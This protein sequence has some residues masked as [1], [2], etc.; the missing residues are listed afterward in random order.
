VGTWGRIATRIALKGLTSMR[1]KLFVAAALSGGLILAGASVP[2]FAA[3]PPPGEADAVA[4]KLDPILELSHTHAKA[5]HTGAG[6]S[7]TANVLELPTGGPLIDGI[8]G[9]TQT[10]VG[11]SEGGLL[12]T[13]DTPL[14]RL[15]LTPWSATV[16]STSTHRHSEAEAAVLRLVLIDPDTLFLNVLQSQSVADNDDTT[17][18]SSGS[19]SSDG[20]VLGLGGALTVDVLHAE[21]SSS[22]EGSSY[23]IGINGNN[24]ITDQDVGGA[25]AIAVD[26]LIDL[27]C[28][29]ASGGTGSNGVTSTVASTV[30]GTVLGQIGAGVTSVGTT[31]GSGTTTA[32]AVVPAPAPAPVVQAAQAAQ[33]P[34]TGAASSVLAMF[35]A[36]LLA[37]GAAAIALTRVRRV[38]AGA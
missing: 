22:G 18:K 34:R 32:P 35:G 23:V 8:L 25:C 1:T 26:P 5:D 36:A 20:A 2:A 7:A 27:T 29:S 21:T 31:S 37:L 4:V 30:D 9:G 11:H 6:S 17:N 19:S 14:G 24:L 28:V 12:D 33:L 10:G 13:G 15:Q 16:T 38:T 3:P